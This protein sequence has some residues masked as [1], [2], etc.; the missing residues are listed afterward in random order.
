MSELKVRDLLSSDVAL[1][2]EK[3]GKDSYTWGEHTDMLK[4]ALAKTEISAE[5]FNTYANWDI[6]NA[7]DWALSFNLSPIK[8][9]PLADYAWEQLNK[10]L[11]D[12]G[13]IVFM[14]VGIFKGASMKEVNFPY[15]YVFMNDGAFE[16]CK[17]L[18]TYTAKCIYFNGVRAIPAYAF[19]GCT[20]LKNIDINDSDGIGYA[21]SV[22]TK[23]F[24]WC[25]NLASENWL[26]AAKDIGDYA[27]FGCESLEE[28]GFV[29]SYTNPEDGTVEV[30]STPI[31]RIGECAF[32]N[33]AIKTLKIDSVAVIDERAFGGIEPLTDVS[34]SDAHWICSCA[35][36]NDTALTKVD[37]GNVN[38]LYDRAFTRCNALTTVIIRNSSNICKMVQSEHSDTANP[39]PSNSN[40]SIYVP[41]AM[42]EKYKADENWAK[43][44]ADN[45][46]A[47]EDYPE[48]TGT[49]E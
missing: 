7:A 22:G 23:A 25:K 27:F 21:A 34:I 17:E 14:P 28:V 40:L 31:R 32:C 5:D 15:K 30:L 3:L 4:E 6:E 13:N 41:K 33:T 39:F 47:I 26:W 2:K 8:E 43:Y 36:I 1:V 42:L 18:E 16:G 19:A 49:A 20:N 9:N 35:F 24:A 11:S 38:E 45:L 12:D 48:I 10:S 37:F 29:I 44:C 46:K